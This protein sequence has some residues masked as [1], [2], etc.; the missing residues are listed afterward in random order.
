MASISV[1]VSLV[2]TYLG[3]EL[4]FRYAAGNER[5]QLVG[6]AA[7]YAA[8]TL[9]WACLYLAPNHYLA[10][11]ALALVNLGGAACNGPLFAAT[12]TLV[13]P[14]LRA[15]SI[16]I[17]LLFSNLI[18]MGLGPLGVGALSDALS[19]MFGQDSLR[20]ALLLL[21]PGSLWAAWHLWQASKDAQDG[22][23]SQ[24]EGDGRTVTE[25]FAVGIGSE[26]RSG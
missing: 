17:L 20:Y 22:T 24:L 23:S 12:Q 26:A 7:V 13:P 21:C 19:P 8:L 11:A 4:A 3:G 16:A 18:G 9:L 10:F 15:M 14:H 5:V 2:G 1:T 6:V 25:E